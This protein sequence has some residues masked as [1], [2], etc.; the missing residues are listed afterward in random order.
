MRKP[1]Q[2]PSPEFSQFVK[3]SEPRL[4]YAFYA[5]YGPEVGADVTAEALAYAW[6]NWT[7][8]QAMDN[9]VGYLYRVGQSKARWYHR[10]RAYFPPP[11]RS[12][13]P[14]VEPK[15][16]EA[17]KRLTRSQRTSV[18]LVAR[19]RVD[20]GRGRCAHRTVSFDDPYASGARPAKTSERVGGDD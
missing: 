2:I 12:V 17:L 6:E 1:Q 10:P 16:P 15:L 20:R 4:S 13:I 9:P 7:R 3:E 18:V 8:I 14:D 11:E 19:G 5:A